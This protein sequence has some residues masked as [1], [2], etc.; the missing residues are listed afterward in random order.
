MP[1]NLVGIKLE[2]SFGLMR[3]YSFYIFITRHDPC[4]RVT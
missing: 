3:S 1:T 4:C 2:L